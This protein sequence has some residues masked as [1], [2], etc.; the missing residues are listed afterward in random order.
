VRMRISRMLP[1]LLAATLAVYA[2]RF[3]MRPKYE[4]VGYIFGRS[5]IVLDGSTVAVKKMTRINYAFFALKNGVIAER[6]EY[7]A[8]NLAV[9]TALRKVNPQ[10]QILISV[11]GGDVGSAGFSDM[12]V[13]PEGRRQFVNSAV[14]AIEKYGLDGVDID[15]EYPG[16]THV[17]T[18]TVR[19][20]DRETYTLLLKELRQRLNREEKRFGRPLVTSSATGATQIWL[21]HTD[22]RAASKWLTTVNMMCYDWYLNEEKNTGHDSPLHT[23]AADPKHI[24]IDDAVKKNLAAGVPARKIIVGVPF[25]GRRWN[26]V[27]ATNNGLWQ[28]IAGNG[29]EI[30]F[31]RIEPLINQ[32]GF[33]RFWDSTAAAS[34]LYNAESKTFITYNDAEAEAARTAYVKKHHLGGIMFWQYTGDPRH[35]LLDAIDAGFGMAVQ[36]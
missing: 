18:T 6:G 9:L 10:L 3:P 36:R 32:Q 7:D 2:A 31:G 14:V 22:M 24:S 20:E 1:A 28:P 15:W 5:G 27:D 11:G 4:V 16:Y 23:V 19:P 30:V 12:A 13:T 8:E 26:G 34:Y 35:T 33:V 17:E 25:Y 21:D 29:E